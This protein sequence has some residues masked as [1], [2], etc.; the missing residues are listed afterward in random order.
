MGMKI[1]F[2]HEQEQEIQ[3]ATEADYPRMLEIWLE[4]SRVGHPF[5]CEPVLREQRE[6][7]RTEYLPTAESWI[8]G[9]TR[10]L[11]FIS[12]LAAHIG[13]LFVDP[14]AAR[15]G[16]GRALVCRAAA[17]HG[18]LTVEVY[19]ANGAAL[20]FYRSLGFRF[21]SRSPTDDEGRKLPL[22]RLIRAFKG[23][24]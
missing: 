13:G 5:L 22:L 11:G 4:A 20:S 8:V 7:V 6:R 19:E 14:A 15:R 3:P 24:G 17:L 23:F 2:P 1:M 16:I 12:L 10:P 9:S 18:A 21:V